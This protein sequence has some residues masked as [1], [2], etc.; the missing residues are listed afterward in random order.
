MRINTRLSPRV[1]LQYRVPERRS[2]GT[3]LGRPRVAAPQSGSQANIEIWER[4]T[5]SQH[6]LSDTVQSHGRPIV[7]CVLFQQA[8][9]LHPD[10]SDVCHAYLR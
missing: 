5:F 3:R 7:G 9:I 10:A 1:Q 8:P 6:V 2:L 4:G